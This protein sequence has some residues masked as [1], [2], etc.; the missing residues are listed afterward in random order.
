MKRY[1]DELEKLAYYKEKIMEQLTRSGVFP[2]A[3]AVDE[4]LA[5]IDAKLSIFRHR[6]A[7]AGGVFDTEQFN[8]EFLEIAE[9]LKIIYRL[10]Y[11]LSVTRYE[12]L[13]AFAET[14][15]SEMQSM[16]RAYEN[17]TRLETESTSLGETVFFQASGYEL[18]F[19]NGI[20]EIQLGSIEATKGARLA[21]IFEADGISPEHVVFS[22]DGENCSP[23][24]LNRDCFFVPGKAAGRVYEYSAL[25]GEMFRTAH[26]MNIP[27]FTPTADNKYVIY[28]GKNCVRDGYQFIERSAQTAFTFTQPGEIEFYVVGGTFIN[29]DFSERPLSQN[30]AGTSITPLKG[31]QNVKME[32]GERFSFDYVTDGIV[33]AKRAIGVVKDGRLYYPYGDRAVDFRVE[34]YCKADKQRYEN[35]KVIVSGIKSNAPLVIKHIAIKEMGREEG[36]SSI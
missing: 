32:R 15:V 23:Y 17:R 16:A 33:Y 5:E 36:G 11:Q 18:S 6:Q 22:F 2:N 4:R 25:D 24:A 12:E 27:G 28:A 9:D 8:K 20:A 13:K 3:L 34:E 29:F 30:F 35:V 14:H 10:A 7:E 1:V 31:V 21:C 26:I 19:G